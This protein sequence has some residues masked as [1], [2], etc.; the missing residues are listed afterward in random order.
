MLFTNKLLPSPLPNER[1]I[2]E[3]RRHWFSFALTSAKYVLLLA[4]PALAYYLIE[5]FEI[6]LWDHLYNGSM[7]E[8]ITRLVISI[9]YLGVWV[10]WFYSW[11]DYYLDVWL[12]TNERVVSLEQ[13]GVFN[14]RVSELRL[15]RV[16]DVSSHVKGL[17]ETFLHFGDIR[18]Q[19]AGEQPNFD[20]YEIPNPY[21]VSERLLRLVDEWNREHPQGKES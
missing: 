8:V 4:A 15:A 12:I 6:S 3:L 13:K 2:M 5:M 20:F 14:R 1:V 17:W 9:Y 21:E 10:F 18:V 19:T 7:T 11:L 16:Q